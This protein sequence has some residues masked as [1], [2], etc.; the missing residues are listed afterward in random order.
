MKQNR[1]IFL[2][3]VLLLSAC[4]RPQVGPSSRMFQKFHCDGPVKPS[5][6]PRG[7]GALR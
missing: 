7:Q 1:K 4:S 2:G 5:D 3:L 6:C